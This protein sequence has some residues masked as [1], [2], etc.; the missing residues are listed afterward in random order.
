[1]SVRFP[2]RSR[3]ANYAIRTA[4][5]RPF[6]GSCR[7]ESEAIVAEMTSGSIV[8]WTGASVTRGASHAVVVDAIADAAERRVGASHAYE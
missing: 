1:M 4:R 6:F 2:P 7:L 8:D 5:G 3:F